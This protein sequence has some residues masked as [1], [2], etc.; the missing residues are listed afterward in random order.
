M[1]HLH[2]LTKIKVY[3]QKP[4]SADVNIVNDG[5]KNA[6]KCTKKRLNKRFATAAKK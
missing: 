2:L 6:K 5:L 3:A 1:E 4:L